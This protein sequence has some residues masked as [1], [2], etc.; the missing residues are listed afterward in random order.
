MEYTFKKNQGINQKA[1][2]HQRLSFRDECYLCLL[3]LRDS[4]ERIAKLYW[5][6]IQ[7]RQTLSSEVSPILITM[8][9]VLI[10]KQQG[11]Q[12][13]LV[14]TYEDDMI[15]MKW[16]APDEQ[17][18]RLACLSDESQNDLQKICATEMRMILLLDQMMKR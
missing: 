14:S 3:C 18:A 2:V 5:R 9:A 1:A 11:L 12:K 7:M 15:R 4:T 6:Y 8:L 13:K 16:H 10:S 17:N